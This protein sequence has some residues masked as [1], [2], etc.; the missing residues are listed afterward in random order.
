MAKNS[1]RKPFAAKTKVE[2]WQN[3]KN[4]LATIDFLFEP[5]YIMGSIS[6]LS[7]TSQVRPYYCA[8]NKR[9]LTWWNFAQ[10]CTVKIEEVRQLW[11]LSAFAVFSVCWAI[12]IVL[13]TAVDSERNAIE[14]LHW[15]H[16]VLARGRQ[17]LH[18]GLQLQR[19][20]IIVS[21]VRLM[22]VFCTRVCVTLC[23]SYSGTLHDENKCI[24]KPRSALVFTRQ[25][26]HVFSMLLII[27]TEFCSPESTKMRYF[28]IKKSKI[29][30]EGALPHPQTHLPVGRGYPSPHP[31][32]SV[33]RL[34]RL[35]RSA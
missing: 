27:K 13:T 19:I 31:T 35:Q 2:I 1:N 15:F 6:T 30:W 8:H 29:F 20:S 11:R 7:G 24:C 5:L 23:F 17:V 33:P 21:I 14:F 18:L 32:P 16:D 3:C 28:E 9:R 12:F 26:K 34:P 10:S 25:L 4:E 22:S